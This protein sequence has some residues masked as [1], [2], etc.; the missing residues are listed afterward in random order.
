MTKCA[1]AFDKGAQNPRNK[2]ETRQV[3]VLAPT[4]ELFT[5]HSS[6]SQDLLRL[7]LKD[8]KFWRIHYY[9]EIP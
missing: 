4:G 3:Y 5:Y 7:L 8:S 9:R 6:Y 2:Q 1:N